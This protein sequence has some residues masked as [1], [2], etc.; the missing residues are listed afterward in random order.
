MSLEIR[1]AAPAEF[2]A[3]A[4]VC[5]AAYAP[6]LDPSPRYVDVLRDVATRAAAAE[7]LV[8][9]ENGNLLGTVT[10]VPD[11]GP[12]GE[13]ATPA[14]TEFRML[15]VDPA[16]QGRGVAGALMECVLA[17]TRRRPGKDGIVC[18]SLPIMRAAHR[19]YDRFGFRR[20][21]ERDWS[22]VPGVTL[23]AFECPL[24]DAAPAAPAAPAR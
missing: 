14:E 21:P 19:V 12:L 23:L 8:A 15:A 10:F 4:D 11:G 7:L 24:D 1:P 9:A 2:D 5:A 13:I 3:V 20:A 17:E 22:P 6:Y 18:S 16:A